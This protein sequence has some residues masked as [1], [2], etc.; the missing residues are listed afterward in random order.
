[1]KLNIKTI[2]VCILIVFLMSRTR[3]IM[4]WLRRLYDSEILTLEPIK[5]FP[6]GARAAITVFVLLLIFIA[7]WELILRR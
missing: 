5:D 7:I 3:H 1:M 2:T 6:D 4:N